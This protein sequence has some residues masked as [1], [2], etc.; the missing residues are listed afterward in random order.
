MRILIVDDESHVLAALTRLLHRELP[1]DCVVETFTHAAAALQRAWEVPFD[2]VVSDYRMPEM[3]GVAF[4]RAF[5]EIQPHPPRLM[6][7]AAA[8]FD[9]LVSAINE[10]GLYR[11]LPKPW[12]EDVLLATLREA[13]AAYARDGE[14]R[15][16]ADERR[17]ELGQL[18]PEELERRRLE[19][20]EPGITRVHWDPNGG[21][22]LDDD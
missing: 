16:L 15:R 7:S 2:A 18:S 8:D 12:D 5:A 22:Q 4:L 3:D 19:A 20:Q 14:A 6:L 9:T 11:Y 21:V 13:L 10:V 17:G 1:R